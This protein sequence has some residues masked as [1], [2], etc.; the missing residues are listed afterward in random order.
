M[1][2]QIYL[3]N[4]DP[5]HLVTSSIGALENLALQSK[6]IKKSLFLDIEITIKIKLG[7]I[8]EKHAQRHNRGEEA[9]LDDCDTETCTSTLTDSYRFKRNS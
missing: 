3:C 1:K 6:A 8:L 9:Y 2:E 5:Y 7:N 4:S